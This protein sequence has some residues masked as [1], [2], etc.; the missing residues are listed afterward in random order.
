MENNISLKNRRMII[1]LLVITFLF[2]FLPFFIIEKEGN[3]VLKYASSIISLISFLLIAYYLKL[4]TNAFL[5]ATYGENELDERQ[6]W[7]KLKAQRDAYNIIFFLVILILL[8]AGKFFKNDMNTF[9]V[10]L[11]VLMIIL[12]IY[13]PTMI[14]AWH[15]KEV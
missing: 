12:R 3:G 6:K 13:L 9:I 1:I 15:E 8:E 10:L 7:I 5:I 14:I 2:I 11:S 4:K